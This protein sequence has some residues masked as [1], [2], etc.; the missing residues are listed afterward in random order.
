MAYFKILYSM[1][2]VHLFDDLLLLLYVSTILF[3]IL[4]DIYHA[5]LKLLFS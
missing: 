4:K 1:S 3:D 5:Y 2:E